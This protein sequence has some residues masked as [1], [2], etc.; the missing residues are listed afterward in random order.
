MRYGKRGFGYQNDEFGFGNVLDLDYMGFG[1]YGAPP[2]V[3]SANVPVPYIGMGDKAMTGISSSSP[4]PMAYSWW[5]PVVEVR[6]SESANYYNSDFWQNAWGSGGH[7]DFS[8]FALQ[9]VER[10][11]PFSHTTAFRITISEGA[12]NWYNGQD[13]NFSSGWNHT[14]VAEG[15]RTETPWG[16]SDTFHFLDT[17]GQN[18]HVQIGN[19]VNDVYH[20]ETHEGASLQVN[21]VLASMSASTSSDVSTDSFHFAIGNNSSDGVNQVVRTASNVQYSDIFGRQ[22]V[23]Q[24]F[25]LDILEQGS[26]QSGDYFHAHTNTLSISQSDSTTVTPGNMLPDAYVIAL[27]EQQGHGLGLG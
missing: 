27:L 25:S 8:S 23:G 22:A 11:T 15:V 1:T 2:L 13:F 20:G 10:F 16:T 6:H 3:P 5:M 14:Y 7:Y 24:S 17:S 18:S 21:T 9:T 19:I 4:V 26:E 12:G